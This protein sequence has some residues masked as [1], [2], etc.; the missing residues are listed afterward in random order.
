MRR[1]AKRKARPPVVKQPELVILSEQ[2]AVRYEPTP[3][4]VCI[5][6]TRPNGF[7]PTLSPRFAAI[8]RLEFTDIVE[9]SPFKWD[10]LFNEQQARQ[11]LDF[12]TRWQR[13][14]VIVIHCMAGQSRS[15][16]IALGLCELF[17]WDVAGLEAQHPL[18]NTWV[19]Q[20]LVRVGRQSS[21]R[22]EPA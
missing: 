12:T 4:A 17:A 18:W 7:L 10:T 20:E 11:V 13:V 6:I 8:L 21:A 1:T 5:S 2:E 22:V 16:G 19:R 3:P 9:P 15:P 14:D